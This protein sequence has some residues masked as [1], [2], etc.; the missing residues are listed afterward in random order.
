MHDRIQPRV[1]PA[2]AVI[3]TLASGGCGGRM[4]PTTRPS[5]EISGLAAGVE[6]AGAGPAS[7]PG[8]YPLTVGNRWKYSEEVVIRLIPNVGE[9]P[10]PERYESTIVRE[11]IGTVEAEGRTYLKELSTE[12]SPF[13]IPTYFRQDASGLYEW[14]PP[15]RVTQAGRVSAAFAHALAGMQPAERAAF[16]LAARRLDAR[17]AAVEAALGRGGA[18]VTDLGF[19]GTGA[20]NELRRLRYPLGPKTQ[21]MLSNDPSFLATCETAGE[22]TLNLPAGRLRGHRIRMSGYLG[23]NDFVH[24]WYGR[25]GFLQLVAHVEVE[26]FDPLGFGRYIYDEREWLTDVTLAGPPDVAQLPPW[27]SR[28]GK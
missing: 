9:A 28:P 14:S 24:L 27:F 10:P 12:P 21:W 25:A 16:E 23:P 7:Q 18:S 1:M 17:I 15:I 26:A 11:I 2:L 22:E 3:L 8:F 20:T 19:P 4:E 13:Q 6:T 5:I